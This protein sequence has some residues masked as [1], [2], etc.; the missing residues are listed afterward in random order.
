MQRD[1][2]ASRVVM[3]AHNRY[4]VSGGAFMIGA[5]TKPDTLWSGLMDDVRI[6]NRAV[7]Q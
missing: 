1:K 7:K 4:A 3:L 5:S 6:Y 2:A